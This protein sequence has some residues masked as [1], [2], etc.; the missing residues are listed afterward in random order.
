MSGAP[1]KR[2]SAAEKKAAILI[3]IGTAVF[4][5]GIF[6]YTISD[7][8]SARFTTTGDAAQKQGGDVH[9]PQPR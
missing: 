5:F 2:G 4:L 9:P 1:T 3:W 8:R 6:A 7:S